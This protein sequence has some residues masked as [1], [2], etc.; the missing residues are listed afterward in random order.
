MAL[1]WTYALD[2][3]AAHGILSYD[4]AADILG[5]KP[6]FVGH[7]T[8]SELPPISPMY[9]PEG[10]KMK[11]SPQGDEFVKLEENDK[12]INNPGWKKFLMGAIALTGI[13]LAAFAL[14]TGKGK[15]KFPKNIK[16]PDM[17]GIKNSIGNFA[18]TV[19][20]F[21]KNI[22]AKIKNLFKHKP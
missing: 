13:G 22:P 12:M 17:S 19:V 8:L 14:I 20:E 7:P 6:R 10:T 18:K 1:D 5:Q 11:D 2:M 4:A 15:I 16:M 3:C 21:I 9:L